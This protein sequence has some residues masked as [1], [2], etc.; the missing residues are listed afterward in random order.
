MMDR[1]TDLADVSLDRVGLDL[2]EEQLPK[3]IRVKKR[4]L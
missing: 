3:R 2:E 4:E 1:L